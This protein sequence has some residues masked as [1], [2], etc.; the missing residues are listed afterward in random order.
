MTR[1]RLCLVLHAHLPFVRHPEH[2]DFLEED[3]LFQAITEAYVPVWSRLLRL[4]EEGVPYGLTMTVSPTLAAMLDDAHL[5]KRLHRYVER[6]RRLA[7]SQAT[8]NLRVAQAFHHKRQDIAL[9]AAQ[10]MTRGCRLGRGIDERL[11]RFW[12]EGRPASARSTNRLR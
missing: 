11:G 3:W 8:G 7:D 10:V 1:G 2:D 4:H 5:R 9:A 6:L 12:S